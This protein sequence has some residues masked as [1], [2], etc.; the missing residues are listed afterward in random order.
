MI[1]FTLMGFLPS[2]VL[3]VLVALIASCWVFIYID[4]YHHKKYHDMILHWYKILGCFWKSKYFYFSFLDNG[5]SSLLFLF[6]WRHFVVIVC[7]LMLIWLCRWSNN[8]KR[9]FPFSLACFLILSFVIIILSCHC[10][11]LLDYNWCLLNV[12]ISVESIWI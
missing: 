5:N 2:I 7:F 12:L 11:N 8:S 6:E 10:H 4:D 3:R 1:S 9:C